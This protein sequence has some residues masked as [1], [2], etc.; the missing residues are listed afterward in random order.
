MSRLPRFLRNSKLIKFLV[1]G[2][3]AAL[4]EYLSFALIVYKLGNNRFILGQVMSFCLGLMISFLLNKLWVFS[5]TGQA[6]IQ[7]IKYVTLAVINILLSSGILKLLVSG[8]GIRPVV[9]K[10]VV[11]GC[12]AVWNYTLFSKFIFRQNAVK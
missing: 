1:S 6:H 7:M 11:M 4:V 9:A 8:A 3:L 2:C 5:A 12:V 10:L